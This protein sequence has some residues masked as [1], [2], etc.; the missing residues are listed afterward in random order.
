MNAYILVGGRSTRMGFPKHAVPFGGTTFLGRVV[1]AAGGAFDR[2][3]AVTRPGGEPVSIETIDEEP[4]EDEAPIFGVRRAIRHASAKCFVIA[5]DFPL[6]DA[7]LLRQLATRFAVSAAPMLVPMFRGRNQVLCAGYSPAVLP[8]I[9]AQIAQGR[10]D[11]QSLAADA[12]VV[13][14]DD[15]ALMSVNT[16]Q[17]LEEAKRLYEQLLASR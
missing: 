14:S 1:E 15:V 4:H 2:V 12:E 10:Y 17:E 3:I 13:A 6:L 11:L 7:N 9:E 5:V 16:I 8:R